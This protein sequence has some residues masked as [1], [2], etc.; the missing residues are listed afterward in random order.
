MT[1]GPSAIA[2]GPDGSCFVLD[3]VRRRVLRLQPD[4]TAAQALAAPHDAEDLAYGDGAL[5]LYSPVRA[6][7]QLLDLAGGPSQELRIPRELRDVQSISIAPSRGLLVRNAFQETFAIGSPLAPAALPSVL[8][9]KR[10]GAAFLPDRTG[11]AVQHTPKATID[12]LVLGADASGRSTV[13][14]RIEVAT[15]ADAGRVLGVSGTV[16][17]VRVERVSQTVSLQVTRELV[18]VDTRNGAAT[19]RV[20][21]PEPGLYVPRSDTAMGGT[22]PQVAWIHPEAE[23]L[24]VAVH[25]VVAAAEGRQP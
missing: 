4:G 2:L 25:P 22:T 1:A 17:C 11:I 16:A 13:A 9:S 5:A 10:E 12:L 24:L 14:R 3:S 19:L 18:C 6:S 8:Q 21:L 20:N 23:G 7:V 15:R